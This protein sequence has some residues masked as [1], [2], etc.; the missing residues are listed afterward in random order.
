MRQLCD[1]LAYLH[2][3][4]IAHRDL[5]LENFL[6]DE[7]GVALISDFGFSVRLQNAKK[8]LLK[9]K[10][11]TQDYMAPEVHM[12]MKHNTYYYDLYAADVYSMGVCL[13]ELTNSYRPFSR[14]FSYRSETIV[15]K[16]KYRKYKFNRKSNVSREL[17]EL[18]HMMLDPIP[19]KRPL[20][21]Q[22]TDHIWFKIIVTWMNKV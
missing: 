11:G 17:H 19:P 3:L 16:K 13:F 20:A 6:V 1:G 18:V 15:H 12:A 8:E 7:N 2:S 9:I 21:N 10:C 4:K 14:G 22:I 5:K